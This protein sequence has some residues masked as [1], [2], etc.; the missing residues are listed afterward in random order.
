MQALLRLSQL[1]DAIN[2][3]I[4][5]FTYWLLP[6]AIVIGTWNAVG[7]YAGKQ[8]GQ[9]LTSN[10]SIEAQ[11]YLFALVFLFGAAYTLKHNAHVRVD[12]LYDR[13]SPQ[14]KALIDFLGTL[15]FLIPFCAMVVWFSWTPILNSW[16]IWESSPDPNGLPRYP[17]KTALLVG[18][19]L[20]ILQGISEAIKNWAIWR[21]HSISA[22]DSH[23]DR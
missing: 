20:L 19:A 16:Q 13:C 12:L 3:R 23:G 8:I 9:S 22:E 17:I 4:G 11:W 2:E 10:A 21:G 7:R 18:F 14:R 5:R 1:I 6:V 15:L